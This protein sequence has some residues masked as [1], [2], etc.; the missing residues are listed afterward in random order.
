M[1]LGLTTK[2]RPHDTRQGELLEPKNQDR[3]GTDSDDGLM[4]A[5]G[6]MLSNFSYLGT[7]MKRIELPMLE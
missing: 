3:I 7:E 4:L 6:Y 2:A 5:T 1:G